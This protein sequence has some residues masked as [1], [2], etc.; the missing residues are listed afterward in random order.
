VARTPIAIAVGVVSALYAL[1]EGINPLLVPQRMFTMMDNSVFIAIPLYLLAGSLMN[2]SGIT[3]R[4]FNFA[5][6]LVGHVRGG[7]AHVNVVAS[8]IFAGMSG[9]AVADSMG[10]GTVE[11]K[12]MT[13][14]GYEVNFSAAVTLA[15]S[16]I[17]PI[18]PPSIVMV[19]YGVTAETSVGGLFLGGIIPGLIMGLCLMAIIYFVALFR[20][21]PKH[22]RDSIKQ[23]GINFLNAFLPLLTPIIIVGGILTGVFTP[24][25]AGVVAVAYTLFVGLFIYRTI[26]LRQIPRILLDVVVRSGVVSFVVATSGIF[27]WIMAR[28]HIPQLVANTFLNITHNR[29][30]LL[31]LINGLLLLLGC[32]MDSVPIIL[33]MVPILMPI[34]QKIGIHPIHFGIIIC[35]NTMIGLITPPVGVCLYG[36]ASVA[37]TS[38]ENIV[39][40]LWPF[41]IALLIAL[42]LITYFPA[43]SMWI[44]KLVFPRLLSY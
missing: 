36:V 14:E 7:L 26:S 3:N 10:L 17:G 27:A 1:I 24:T 20:R 2:T 31:L 33:I 19:I 13:D 44:P 40:A 30:L 38:I 6:S 32:F 25:E 5:R 39:K 22:P 11:M 12:A 15:S 9:S 35:V 43:L 4:I 42:L 16:T 34:L 18:I 29:I 28:E 23:L 8:I 37:K 21:Y 41:F